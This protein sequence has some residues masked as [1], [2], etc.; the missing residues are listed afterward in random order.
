MERIVKTNDLLAMC[1]SKG[2]AYQ[3]MRYGKMLIV[4]LANKSGYLLGIKYGTDCVAVSK[5]NTLLVLG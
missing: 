2:L 1:L 3:W 4:K 5:I